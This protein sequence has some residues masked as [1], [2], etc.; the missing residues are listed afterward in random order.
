[1]E[2]FH[3]HINGIVQGVGFRPLIYN[4]ANKM[5]LT[6]FVKNNS[7]GLNIFFNATRL[8]AS[9]FFEQIKL[10]TPPM[11]KIISCK[12]I[13]V[14]Q[15][16]F[17]GFFILVEEEIDFKKEV[18]LSPDLCM[19]PSCRTELL[20]VKNRRYRYPF[21]TCTHC[22]PRY[23]MIKKLPYERH[24]TTMEPFGQCDSC[25]AEYTDVN[26]RRF[27]SQTNSCSSCGVTL[28]MY[29]KQ[30]TIIANTNEAVLS[31]INECL[32]QG[33]IIAVKGIGGYLLL[34]DAGN[35]AVIRQLR[36]RKFRP[37]KP[38]AVLYPGLYMVSDDFRLIETETK[39]LES[40]AAPI[41][42]LQPNDKA[43]DRLAVNEIA[44]GLNRVGVMIPSN[45]LLYLIANDFGRPLVATSANISGSPIIYLDDDALGTLFAIADYVVTH[46]REIV[47]PQDDSVVQVSYYTHQSLMLR[48]SRGYA[49]SF[50]HY[51]ATAENCIIA[52]G[53]YLKSSFAVAV[54]GNV[55]IS[56]FLG[57]GESFESQLMYK[58]TLN[59]WLQLYSINPQIIVADRHPGYFS[60]QLAKELSGHYK[61]TLK[62]V[63]HHEAHFAA[64]LAENNLIQQREPVLG[65]IWDGTGLGTDGNIWG[66]EFFR[67]DK[68][69]VERVAQ[70]DYFP[71][72]AG[73]KTA[74]EPRLA[75]LCA[76]GST[77]L[78][79]DMLK[80]KFTAVE[81]TNYQA[82]LKNPKLFTSSVGRI[83]DAVAS[84]LGL[85]DR[86]SFEGEAAMYLQVL[87]EKYVAENGF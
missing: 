12:L 74:L 7:N 60:S 57:S 50:L 77:G 53:A 55:F 23:S 70:F 27:F 11:A 54:N 25:L 79:S 9:V 72:I 61:T 52:T 30:S 67:Y 8:Q 82:L 31:R 45:P 47:I 59:H 38:F 46:N 15:R 35:T 4:L 28:R 37:S 14:N 51:P 80:N 75:A 26:N 84:L 81:W 76:C 33:K 10:K 5:K 56:Q 85:C 63:Q 17:A 41:V 39:L 48:R 18:M 69:Q 40:T 43:C 22:G 87:A 62:V 36:E 49:P 71:T 66:G 32:E 78:A 83:F 3:I 13:Q 34:C 65:V 24:S 20:D 19:C 2:T 6:G 21:I 86:Q 29:Q 73:D 68:K 44:P 58:N 1:M 16:A 64:V 42:L